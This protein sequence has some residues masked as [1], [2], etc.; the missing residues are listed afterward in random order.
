MFAEECE[1]SLL[2]QTLTQTLCFS[3]A[4]IFSLLKI[5]QEVN[6]YVKCFVHWLM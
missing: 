5:Q 6:T 1:M 4:L 3:R 2:K